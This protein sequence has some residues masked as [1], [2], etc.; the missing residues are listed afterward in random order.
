V[1]SAETTARQA[2]STV[3][4]VAKAQESVLDALATQ[5]ERAVLIPVG[6][7]LIAR[8][9]VV[10]TIKPYVKRDTAQREVTK[11][12]KRYERRGTTARNKLERQLKRTRTQLERNLRQRRNRV[13]S[14]VKRN[15]RNIETTV[16]GAS[17]DVRA[18][19]FQ[20]AAERVQNGVAK[21]ADDVRTRVP[22]LV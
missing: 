21:T 22:N 20:R 19:E 5:A 3:R 9:N 10:E 7:T 1:T 8:D 14:L 13:E 6:A 16:K 4:N 2:A 11:S 18:G 17:R 15:S 12:L